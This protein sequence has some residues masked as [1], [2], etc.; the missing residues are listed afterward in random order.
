MPYDKPVIKIGRFRQS[1][2]TVK[3]SDEILPSNW[4]H[5]Q[6]E[7]NG[8]ERSHSL[9]VQPIHAPSDRH[10]YPLFARLAGKA[11]PCLL[12]QGIPKPSS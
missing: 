6:Y 10:L 11:F 7:Q 5:L 8:F 1:E 12:R 9:R 4:L 3:I 2:E